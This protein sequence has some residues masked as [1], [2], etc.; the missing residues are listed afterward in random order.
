MLSFIFSGRGGIHHRHGGDLRQLRRNAMIAAVVS[1][2]HIL[3][4]RHGQ[5]GQLGLAIISFRMGYKMLTRENSKSNSNVVL[6]G[7]CHE[8]D[9]CKI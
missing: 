1:Y 2:V 7:T 6:N 4:Y 8:F 5:S 9:S 3:E